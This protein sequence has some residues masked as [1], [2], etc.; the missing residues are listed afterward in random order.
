MLL[1]T[2]VE[3]IQIPADRAD[4]IAKGVRDSQSD[5]ERI[6]QQT[7]AGATQRRRGV[8]AKLDRGYWTTSKVAFLRASGRGNRRSGK[9]S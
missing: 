1:G 8:Q 9:R 6:R 3:G 5:M 7:L 4:W 2:L